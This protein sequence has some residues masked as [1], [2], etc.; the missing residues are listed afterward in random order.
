MV[1]SRIIHDVQYPEIQEVADNDKGKNSVLF[2]IP[3]DDQEITIA[4]GDVKDRFTNHN[5]FYIPIYLK[6]NID[7]YEYDEA[8]P[9]GIYEF[10]ME[11]YTNIFDEDGDVDPNKL[12]E[13]LYFSFINK[14]FLSGGGRK[15]IPKEENDYTKGKEW[16]QKF[17]KNRNYHVT[18]CG[19][20]G[21]CFFFVIW[22]AF[23]KSDQYSVEKLRQMLSDEAN[24]E[25]YEN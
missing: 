13:P 20:G 15:K 11:N 19:G 21:D 5:L 25:L 17:M 23:K 22:C 2:E 8:I 9:I 16:I 18:D 4:L 6:K 12:S 1:Q 7:H 24:D 3:Y 14:T 10:L